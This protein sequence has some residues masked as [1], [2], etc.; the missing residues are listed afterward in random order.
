MTRDTPGDSYAPSSMSTPSKWGWSRRLAQALDRAHVL[1]PTV[2]LYET[3]LGVRG[4]LKSRHVEPGE[5]PPIPPAHL[6]VKVAPAHGD[7]E[8]FL[9]S[10]E[11]HADLIRRFLADVESDPVAAS[12]IL[13]FG[14]GCGRVAR[15]W[16]GLDVDLRGCDVNP[17][18][19]DWC[20]RNM[21]FGQYAVT[22]MS[23][24]LPYEDDAFGLAY[25]LSV[26]THLP[27]ALQHEWLGEFRR[28]LRPGGYLVVSTLGE[29]YAGLGRL[30]D[31]ERQTFDQ[32][33]LVVLFES[34]AGGNVCSVY[35]PQAY[36]EGTLADGFDYLAFRKGTESDHHDM[37]LLRAPVSDA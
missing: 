26:F 15:H 28:V 32:G 30:T 16:E 9:T 31:D 5:G 2:S 11:R 7:L 12:P 36:V 8:E 25:V 33:A 13:D 24:P 22:G 10:G 14:V 29:Y 37:H 4:A 27:E 6:R 17:R 20:R 1:G 23:P 19:I 35:H 34:Q 21:P 3:T 18:M